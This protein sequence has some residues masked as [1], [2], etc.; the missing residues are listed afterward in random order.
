[1]ASSRVLGRVSLVSALLAIAANALACGKWQRVG[2]VEAPDPGQYVARLFDATSVYRDMG[3]FVAEDQIPFVASVRFLAGPS[4]DS[5]IAIVGVS[6]ANTALSFRRSGEVYEAR[7]RVELVFR[8]GEEVVLRSR[9]SETVRLQSLAETERALENV[10]FQQFVHIPP[11]VVTLTITVRDQNAT[12]FGEASGQIDVPTFGAGLQLSSLIPVYEASARTAR[13]A[14][15]S[16]VVNVKGAIPYGAGTLRLFLE[17]YDRPAGDTI[18]VRAVPRESR[19]TEAWRTEVAL[20]SGRPVQ[21]LVV[22]VDAE[23]LPMGEVYFEAWVPGSRDTVRATALVS[24]SDR[25]VVANFEDM[26]SLLRY[27]GAESAIREMQQ[28]APDQR[29]GLWRTFWE[30]TDPDPQTPGNEAME[31]YFQRLHEANERFEEPGTP[32]WLTDRGEVFVTLGPPDEIFDSSSDLEGGIRY[33]RWTYIS[34]RLR[35][36]YLDESGFGRFLMTSLSR[37]EFMR[38]VNRERRRG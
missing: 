10:V 15:P 7:Y 21:G 11:G 24:F 8:R 5:T 37:A 12:V 36:E 25:W 17:A 20:E 38:V 35:L 29:P 4:E 34:A 27:F 19:E 31:L 16:A 14:S 30:T 1:M 6:M 2:T 23:V 26:L 13:S 3:L 18:V 33:I 9:R 22:L 32:G 28:A